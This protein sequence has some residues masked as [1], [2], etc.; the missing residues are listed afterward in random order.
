[1]CKEKFIFDDFRTYKKGSNEHINISQALIFREERG[2]VFKNHSI[3][4][5]YSDR[6]LG[7]EYTRRKQILSWYSDVF[8]K[9]L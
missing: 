2:N 6:P 4:V 1:M 5:S 9:E 3:F 8:E 7:F